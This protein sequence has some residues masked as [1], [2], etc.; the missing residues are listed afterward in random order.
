MDHR[1]SSSGKKSYGQKTL[2]FEKNIRPA[3]AAGRSRGGWPNFS[4]QT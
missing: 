3:A 1:A 2:M 4:F